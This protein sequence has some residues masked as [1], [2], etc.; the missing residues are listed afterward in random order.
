MSLKSDLLQTFYC[1]VS[2]VKYKGRN[3]G[4]KQS[5]SNNNLSPIHKTVIT[6]K[7]IRAI[8]QHSTIFSHIPPPGNVTSVLFKCY[9]VCSFRN[10]FP[11]RHTRVD[12]STVEMHVMHS[13]T[14]YSIMPVA[15]EV[16]ALYEWR[17]LVYRI[18]TPFTNNDISKSKLGSR[19]WVP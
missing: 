6:K 5:D 8:I 19:K 14:A 2:I 1:A 3:T 13:H 15:E 18:L 10:T 16:W 17:F 11:P 9:L 12:M 7:I 4:K